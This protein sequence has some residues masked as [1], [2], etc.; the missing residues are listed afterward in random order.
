M[1]QK[2]DERR[3][4]FLNS[5]MFSSGKTMHELLKVGKKMKDFK[6]FHCMFSGKTMHEEPLLFS[7]FGGGGSFTSK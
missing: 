3:F 4:L 1:D 2:E 7:L 5:I 6:K